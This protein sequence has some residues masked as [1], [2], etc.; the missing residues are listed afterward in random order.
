M[1]HFLKLRRSQP[2]RPRPFKVWGYPIVPGIILA[3]SLAFLY[4]AAVEEPSSVIGAVALLA[5]S[6]PVY[7]L[8]RR[9]SK[10]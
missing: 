6:Y 4:G 3:V 2:D 8:I 5:L 10:R 7:R 1:F 9:Q